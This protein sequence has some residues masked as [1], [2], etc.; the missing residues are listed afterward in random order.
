MVNLTGEIRILIRCGDV[1]SPPVSIQPSNMDLSALLMMSSKY[2]HNNTSDAPLV[3]NITAMFICCLITHQPLCKLEI[4][5]P[6]YGDNLNCLGGG[7][8][9]EESIRSAQEL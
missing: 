6:G 2:L 3:L 8:G 1:P 4:S 7:R 5:A 9:W